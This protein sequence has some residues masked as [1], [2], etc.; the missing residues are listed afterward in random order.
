MSALVYVYK[1]LVVSWY[2]I[3]TDVRLAACVP[4]APLS[5]IQPLVHLTTRL[6][7]RTFR[8]AGQ[9]RRPYAQSTQWRREY[10]HHVIRYFLPVYTRSV[11]LS[12]CLIHSVKACYDST[13]EHVLNVQST[14]Y[15]CPSTSTKSSAPLE[16][17]VS[18]LRCY[19]LSIESRNL[20]AVF[21][22]RKR[23]A[24][25]LTVDGRHACIP[26][27]QCAVVRWLVIKMIRQRERTQ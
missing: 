6:I 14:V 20:V 18:H 19:V 12:L 11:S 2:I 27:C 7:H 3:A 1:G 23:Q 4:C 8:S 10:H 17:Q 5:S 26:F 22:L 13:D 25:Y 21:W 9:T 15:Y 24:H 16:P